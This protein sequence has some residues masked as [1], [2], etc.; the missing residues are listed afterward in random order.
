MCA[1][2]D[3]NDA[4]SARSPRSSRIH[5][6]GRR[7]AR[8]EIPPSAASRGPAPC[9]TLSHARSDPRSG[10][11]DQARRPVRP[12]F[13]RLVRHASRASGKAR[14]ALG[15]GGRRRRRGGQHLADLSR[16][17]GRRHACLSQAHPRAADRH[18]R[19]DRAPGMG[20]QSSCGPVDRLGRRVGLAAAGR[21][22]TRHPGRAAADR[23]R[24]GASPL[25]P[26]GRC[27]RRRTAHPPAARRIPLRPDPRPMAGNPGGAVHRPRS[28]RSPPGRRAHPGHRRPRPGW[29][30]E[31][32]IPETS[33]SA[34]ST[35]SP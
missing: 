19:G 26:P 34:T 29:S 35:A 10:R 5:S 17:A 13:P 1:I 22:G 7:T 9:A 3:N 2:Q 16:T 12:W 20:E 23:G 8:H 27:P 31:T 24:R 25:A 32:C 30:T 15:P 21:R 28:P 33:S 6:R 14:P 11:R 4:L 18:H